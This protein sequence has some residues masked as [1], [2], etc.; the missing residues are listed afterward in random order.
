MKNMPVAA[1]GRNDELQFHPVANIFPLTKGAE[2][3]ALVADI[4]AHGLIEPIV[5]HEGM[6]LDGRNRY[7]ACIEAGVEPAF[8]PFTGDDPV[9]FVI[10][11]N[12]RRRHLSIEDKDR[13]IVA[14]LQADPT[15]SNRQVAKVVNASHPHVAKVRKR[16]EWAGDVETVTTSID[17]KCR[18]QPARKKTSKTATKRAQRRAREQ[19]KQHDS[20]EKV[21]REQQPAIDAL[22]ARLVELDRNVARGVFEALAIRSPCGYMAGVNFLLAEPFALALEKALADTQCPFSCV[23][24]T[25]E[26]EAQSDGGLD[27]PDYLLRRA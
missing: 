18:K 9:A 11:A 22:A 8:R 15:K 2:F 13:L 25:T 19:K 7:R 10:S 26:V 24:Q 5:M 27:I 14:L 6:I 20:V 23:V 21:I 16:A 1:K 3:D 4:K 12:I 17:T